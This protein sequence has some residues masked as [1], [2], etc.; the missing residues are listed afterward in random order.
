M[1]IEDYRPL[2]IAGLVVTEVA[3]WQWRMVVAARGHRTGAFALGAVGAV[4]QITAI[5]QVVSGVS[6]PLSVTAYAVGVGAGVLLG[7]LA[8]DRFSP[9]AVRMTIVTPEDDVAEA[10]WSRGWPVTVQE[11]QGATGPLTVLSVAVERRHEARLHR[12][13]AVLA[14]DASWVT[15]DLRRRAPVPP[16]PV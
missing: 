16:V 6:D 8:G 3:L 14:P 11:G 9:G 4:L 13:L 12:D 2:L 7:M 15:D 10:L 1:A 5:T